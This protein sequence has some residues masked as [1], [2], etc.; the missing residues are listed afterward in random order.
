MMVTDILLFALGL[1]VLLKG[2]SIFTDNASRIAKSLGVSQIVIGLTLVAFTTSLPELAVSVLSVLREV[3]GI[4]IGNIV[5][6]NI[7]N[8]GLV[9]GLAALL[10]PGIL[11]RRSELKQGYIMLLVTLIA[12]IFIAGGLTPVK[13]GILILGLIAY[14]YY[15]SKEKDFK[16]SIV[17]KTT[18]KANFS[19]GTV[20]CIIGGAGVLV[21]AELVVSASMNIASAF[22]IYDTVIGLT[23]VAVGTS[24][25]ELA[26]SIT[27]AFKKLQGIALGN[28]IGSNIFN[29]MMVM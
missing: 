9:L 22:N 12:V 14:V 19:K 4:A 5:G 8:V 25:P 16:L 3:P 24:L 15:L 2:A 17:E 23:L 26:V 29:L 10:T 7:A 1:V 18:E 21:G 28:I 27:A 11:V 13:G 6:S 20:L